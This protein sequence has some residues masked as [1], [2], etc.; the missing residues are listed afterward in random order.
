MLLSISLVVRAGKD[1]TY[2]LVILGGFALTGFLFWMV[3]SE[4]FFSTSPSSVFT[5]ALKKVK[6]DPRVSYPSLTKSTL[7]LSNLRFKFL[8]WE[9]GRR[10]RGF[11]ISSSMRLVYLTH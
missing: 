2:I 6:N 10:W 11:W 4:F 3:G 5:K 7:N 8:V 1:F 9:E